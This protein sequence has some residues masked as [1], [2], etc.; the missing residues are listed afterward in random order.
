MGDTAD[1]DP[2]SAVLVHDSALDDEP[3]LLA[4]AGAAVRLCLRAVRLRA[5]IRAREERTAEVRSRLLRAADDQRRELER[6]LHDGAQTRLVLALMTLRR[7]GSLLVR[8]DGRDDRTGEEDAAL[9]R[10]VVE[11]EKTLRQALEDLRELAQ[12]IHPALLTREGIGPA[13][14]AVAERSPLPAEVTAE[15][16]RYPPFIESAA[17]SPSARHCRT[18][19]STPVPNGCGSPCGGRAHCWSSRSPTTVPA[20]RTPPAAPD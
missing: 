5:E 10:A 4:A 17:Y 3:E 7:A 9:R 11:A 12:G 14:T 6:N 13:V 20:A 16:G 18:P 1:E 2:H 8:G 19:S 15:P